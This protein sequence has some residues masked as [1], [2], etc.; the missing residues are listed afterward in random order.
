MIPR[1]NKQNLMLKN[2]VLEAVK[3]NKFHIY[4]VATVAEGIEILTGVPASKPNKK[5]KYPEG[6]VYG[7]VQRKLKQYFERSYKIKKALGGQEVEE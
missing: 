1:A 7:A 5:G 3:Q 2:E 4:Q 6:S